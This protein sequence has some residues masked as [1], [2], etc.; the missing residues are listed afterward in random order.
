MKYNL[1]IKI[2]S[3]GFFLSS[4]SDRL[5]DFSASER[6]GNNIVYAIEK[7]Y[8]DKHVY[9]DSLELL[10]PMYL[11]SIPEVIMKKGL[12]RNKLEFKYYLYNVI[13][14]EGCFLITFDQKSSSN[15]YEY[16]SR[17]DEI[18]WTGNSYMNA[19][20]IEENIT[21]DD[22]KIVIQSIKNYFKD[23]ADYPEALKDLVPSHL[24]SFPFNLNAKYRP[25]EVAPNFESD[26][27]R[28]NFYPPSDTFRG[29]YRLFF[30]VAFGQYEYI[31]NGNWYYND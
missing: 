30:E 17:T 10:I 28:Y 15:E 1:I 11:D 4:C 8:K 5:I 27:V 23:S 18:N 24:D 9:P 26:L 13:P 14:K 25:I 12:N 2:L 21:F 22:I 3:L 20:N 7:Y 29:E 6:Q 16:D 31:G 19:D